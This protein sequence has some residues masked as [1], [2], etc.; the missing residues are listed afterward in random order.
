MRA[1]RVVLV[2]AVLGAGYL[3]FKSTPKQKAKASEGG[4]AP[5]PGTGYTV[6]GAGNWWYRGQMIYQDPRPQEWNI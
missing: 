5:L 2:L 4:H 1:D 6:D 3:L